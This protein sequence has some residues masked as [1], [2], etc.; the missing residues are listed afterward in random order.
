MCVCGFEFSLA[1][2]FFLGLLI[3]VVVVIYRVVVFP[4]LTSGV[5]VVV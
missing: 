5:V 2:G 1:V 4:H 3:A